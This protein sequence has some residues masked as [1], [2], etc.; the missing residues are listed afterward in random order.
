MPQ[1]T[2][3]NDANKLIRTFVLKKD[4]VNMGTLEVGSFNVDKETYDTLSNTTG[5]ATSRIE[6]LEPPVIGATLKDINWVL[7][8]ELTGT[9]ITDVGAA[10]PNLATDIGFPVYDEQVSAVNGGGFTGLG[11]V[12]LNSVADGGGTTYTEGTD[13]EVDTVN[14]NVIL[15]AAGAI[16]DGATVYVESGTYTTTTGKKIYLKAGKIDTE[17][18]FELV[19]TCTDGETLTVYLYKANITSGI[20]LSFQHSPQSTIPVTITG[21]D[22]T[23]NHSD[24]PFGYILIST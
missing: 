15:I 22:D 8:S 23:A 9:S 20:D 19:H 3:P 4:T 11:S 5:K 6:F 17:G 16:T 18:A 12:V 10:T 1:P 24:D 7:F 13:Y 2:R 21:L 14:G